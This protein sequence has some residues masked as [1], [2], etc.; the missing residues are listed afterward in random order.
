MKINYNELKNK[1][2]IHIKNGDRLGYICDLEIDSDTG[3]I[4]SLCVPGNY[5]AFGLF[6]KED[7]IKIDW[8]RIKKIGEDLIIIE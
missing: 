3:K 7:D 1:E 4:T 2:I 5:K 8:E 6:G